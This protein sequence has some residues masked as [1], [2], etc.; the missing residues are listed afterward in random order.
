MHCLLALLKEPKVII[1]TIAIYMV[2]SLSSLKHDQRTYVLSE[3]RAREL[4]RN[5]PQ[6][7]AEPF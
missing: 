3:N 5:E 1:K 6:E 2:R 4:L 7:I